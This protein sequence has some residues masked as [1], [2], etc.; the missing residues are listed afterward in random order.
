[1]SRDKKENSEKKGNKE[2]KRRYKKG[3]KTPSEAERDYEFMHYI[4]DSGN[5]EAVPRDVISSKTKTVVVIL[6]LCLV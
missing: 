6:L 4:E 5:T 2:N 1:M 3:G